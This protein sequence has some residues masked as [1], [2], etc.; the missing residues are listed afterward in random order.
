MNK[1]H[2]Y[3]H[4][5]P[6]AFWRKAIAS[7]QPQ[8]VDPV[9]NFKLKIAKKMKV[10]TAG[11]CF[12]QHIARHL[13]N[14]GFNYYV[15]EEGHPILTKKVKRDFNYGTFSARFGNIYT[16]KQLV[17]LSQRAFGFYTPK[18]NAWS[19]DDGSIRD[20]FRP[21]IQPDGFI[22]EG[23]MLADQK[24]HLKTVRKMFETL[25]VFVF[26]LGLTECWISKKDGSV[27]PICP[28]VE[29]GE[30]SEEKYEFYNQTV[31]DVTDDLRMFVAL[32][33]SVNP[34]AQ[35][36]LT[37][38]PVPLMATA[39]ADT[40]V[41]TATTYSKS[42]LRVAAD[43]INQEFDHIHYFPSYEII[44]GNFNRG[45]YYAEDLRNVLENG[46]SHV[47]GLFLKH[48]T[49]AIDDG[50]QTELIAD[51]KDAQHEAFLKQAQEI[52][53]VECDEELLDR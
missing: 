31:F 7:C 37:V 21:N 8:Y 16:T 38:S 3:K 49:D 30:F 28:G 19:H 17:Q 24:Q 39:E 47:M 34:L 1:N 18:E 50:S 44:T 43:I 22:S 51:D 5:P 36:I 13:Q 6:S 12:A 27:F 46:V 25:D 45:N 20:P 14:S 40:H 41:L 4:L 33:K 9:V 32:L 29:G 15:A 48:A 53:D 26:T 2:P 42:V 52:V 35:I 11:S 23:E 10:A